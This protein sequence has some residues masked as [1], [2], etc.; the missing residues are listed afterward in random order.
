MTGRPAG[1]RV[2]RAL[3]GV[4]AVAASLAGCSSG[5]PSTPSTPVLRLEVT[6]TAFVDGGAIPQRSTCDGEDVSPELQWTAAPDGTAA[7]AVVVIDRD[8]G[9]FVHWVVGPLPA[10]TTELPEGAGSDTALPQGDND[11][12]EPGW[13]GPCPPSGTHRYEFR[14][15]ALA[16]SPHEPLTANEA[17]GAAALAS[18][19]LTGSYRHG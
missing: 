19:T 2:A 4:A 11:F 7:V 14:V 1:G 13:G 15:I 9:G 5:T 16:E 6:S 3:L 10:T 17:L 12:G 18:G 8:A